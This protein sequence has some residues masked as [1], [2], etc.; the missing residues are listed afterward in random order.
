MRAPTR[1]HPCT[2]T[3]RS[4]T[5]RVWAAASVSIS[6]SRIVRSPYAPGCQR[7]ATRETEGSASLSR[8]RRLG[9]S[10]GPRKVNPV[11]FPPG[12]DRL[13]TSPSPTGSP[14]TGTTIGIEAVASCAAR[15][16]G[17]FGA[18]MTSTLR[19]IS[20]LNRSGN[21]L[22]LAVSG[23][24]LNQRCSCL[25]RSPVRVVP[26][27]RSRTQSLLIGRQSSQISSAAARPTI[28]GTPAPHPKMRSIPAASLDPRF[29][30]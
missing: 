1:L 11:M 2:P 5:P 30:T 26:V 13:A 3:R 16:A 25:P 12:R 14:I 28:A 4:C 27:G 23:S 20:S 17:V 18:T 6:M 21:L 8:A 10:S 29:R 9:T 22:H 7:A 19:R 15:A 24:V